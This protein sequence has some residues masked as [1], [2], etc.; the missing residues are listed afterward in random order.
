MEEKMLYVLLFIGFFMDKT[1]AMIPE[2]EE[3]T[4]EI[5][6][7]ADYY[8]QMDFQN[9]KRHL[10]EYY[11]KNYNYNSDNIYQELEAVC[12]YLCN[13]FCK[14]NTETRDIIYNVLINHFLAYPD[15]F[16]LEYVL[17]IPIYEYD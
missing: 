17:N 15:P 4:Q 5:R 2:N 13:K 7:A 1:T 10:K 16:D 8:A 6:L 14:S 11:E 9:A 3:V 12:H